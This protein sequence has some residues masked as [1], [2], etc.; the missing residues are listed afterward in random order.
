MEADDMQG[1]EYM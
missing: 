1:K